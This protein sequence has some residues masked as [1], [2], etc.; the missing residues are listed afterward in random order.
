[1]LKAAGAYKNFPTG[2]AEEIEI[3]LVL[4]FASSIGAHL[5]AG[6]GGKNFHIFKKGGNGC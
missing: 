4:D 2:E 3:R 5:F 1:M 6:D